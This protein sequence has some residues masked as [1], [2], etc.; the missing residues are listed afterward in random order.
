M[1]LSSIVAQLL[2]EISSCLNLAYPHRGLYIF[3]LF[4]FSALITSCEPAGHSQGWQ[5]LDLLEHGPAVSI[6]APT[7]AEVKKGSF[8]SNLMNDLT[9]KG[10]DNYNLQIFYGP[11]ITNDIAKL[12]ND[13]LQ[14]AQSNRYF[15]R[16]VK[17]EVAGFIYQSMIDSLETYSFNFTKLQGEME[18]NFQSGMGGIFTLEEAHLMYEGVK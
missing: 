17:E 10:G 6:M 12:K 9:V 7:D 8:G 18:L 16:I 4:L 5:P 14:I 15:K 3:V 13:Q 11:A 2:Q 1:L